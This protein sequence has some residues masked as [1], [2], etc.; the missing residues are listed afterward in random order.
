MYLKCFTEA[1]CG[2]VKCVCWV[3]FVVTCTAQWHLSMVLVCHK[4]KSKRRRNIKGHSLSVEMVHVHVCES[5]HGEQLLWV[6]Y[7]TYIE[8][9]YYI[10]LCLIDRWLHQETWFAVA[11]RRWTYIYDNQG[12]ELHCLKMLDSVLRM[13]YLPYH[14][15]L[16]TS[17]SLNMSVNIFMCLFLPACLITCK[18][19]TD[20]VEQ[21]IRYVC[22]CVSVTTLETCA[23]RQLCSL[24]HPSTVKNFPHP[25]WLTLVQLFTHPHSPLS[26]SSLTRT[27]PC[28]TLPSPTLAH[29]CPPLPSPAFT[30][31]RLFPHPLV[32]VRLFTCLLY[33][34]PSP[35]D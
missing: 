30:H 9:C 16:A 33:T 7:L 27:R 11:Q 2:V 23:G 20:Q 32:L 34:S 12:I 10:E 25:R 35:R 26:N 21:L 31:V 6:I 19:F 5:L 24:T 4:V 3:Q 13:E 14:A 8:L 29:P 28:P 1:C 17:V 22:L 18:N 15:L